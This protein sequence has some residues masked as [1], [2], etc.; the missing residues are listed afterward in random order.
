MK[1]RAALYSLPLWLSLAVMLLLAQPGWTHGGQ[2]LSK[3]TLKK[4]FPQA[5]NFVTKP[6]GLSADQH[7]KIEARIGAKLEDHDLKAPAYIASSKGRS[8]GIVWATDAH[9]KK[10][11]ADVIV[12]VDLEGNVTGVVLDHSKVAGLDKPAYLDQY[13]KLTTKS[14][15][16]QGK[17]LKALAG[18]EPSSKLI[19]AC[20][21]KAAV[22]IDETYLSK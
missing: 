16:Q 1:R 5:D 7:K 8:V 11:N 3:E 4:L 22:I 9:L 15:F 14:S 20:A 10:G 18:Q 17:D 21:K 13:K 2:A 12:G 6:L 19:A